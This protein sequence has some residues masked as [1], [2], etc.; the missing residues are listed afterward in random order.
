MLTGSR[1]GDLRA[2][3]GSAPAREA[4]R[5]LIAVFHHDADPAVG[6]EGER[7][8]GHVLGTLRL[9]RAV[10][11]GD[12][13]ADA[14]ADATAG[15]ETILAARSLSRRIGALLRSAG[16]R[17]AGGGV[18]AALVERAER[19]GSVEGEGVAA[20]VALAL[21]LAAAVGRRDQGVDDGAGAAGL[22]EAVRAL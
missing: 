7:L 12:E 22:V 6:V 21:A 15:L 9:A 14:L 4:S 10:V 16:A 13:G 2:D 17:G 20:E 5:G 3:R 11:G 18:A 19:S 8:A 1:R